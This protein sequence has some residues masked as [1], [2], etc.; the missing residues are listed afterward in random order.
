MKI[1]PLL[2]VAIILIAVAGLALGNPH[3]DSWIVK[4]PLHTLT[5][6]QCPLCGAQR[7][8]HELLHGNIQ[9]AWMLNPGLFLF[10]PYFLLLFAGIIWPKL[11]L[12]NR[13]VRF[14]YLDATI[15]AVIGLLIVWG[16]IRNVIHC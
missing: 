2:F 13:L 7:M 10:T 11:Q 5:G 3:S 9:E 14:A 15:F 6:L 8:V 16:I 12:D 1:K 4:C